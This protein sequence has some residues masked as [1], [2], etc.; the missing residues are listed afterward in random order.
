MKNLV[1]AVV[2]ATLLLAAVA[3]PAQETKPVG[4]SIRAGG[5]FPT[6][7]D[8]RDESDLWFALGLEY[9]L[10]DLTYQE[11]DGS[12]THLSLS[13]DWFES[14]DFR[15]FPVLLNLVG[16]KDQM[17]YSVG[18]GLTFAKHRSRY[19]PIDGGENGWGGGY[20]PA[21]DSWRTDEDTLF[22]YSLGIGYQFQQGQTPVFLEARYFGCEKSELNGFAVYVG[23][24][25]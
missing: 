24:R 5:F 11:T 1:C 13:A 15:Q 6:D 18:V 9:K 19:I 2:A 21:S 8:A 14:G 3:A 10:K 7:S 23:V 25:L 12:A 17:Y 22:A 4:L 16:T 20:E